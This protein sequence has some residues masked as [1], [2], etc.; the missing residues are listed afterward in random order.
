MS[1]VQRG[2]GGRGSL[3]E[4]CFPPGSG[5]HPLHPLH[6]PHPRGLQGLPHSQTISGGF[7][8]I[9]PALRDHDPSGAAAPRGQ[10]AAFAPQPRVWCV[11]IPPPETPQDQPRGRILRSWALSPIPNGCDRHD[12]TDFSLRHLLGLRARWVLADGSVWAAVVSTPRAPLLPLGIALFGWKKKG[13]V[14]VCVGFF[15]PAKSLPAAEGVCA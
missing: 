9:P 10:G 11:C 6:P 8:N 1:W 7:K 12:N 3:E 15:T 2:S 14:C 4:V 5:P 13:G